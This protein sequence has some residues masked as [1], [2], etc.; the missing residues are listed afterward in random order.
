MK[1]NPERRIANNLWIITA[2][3]VVGIFAPSVFGMDGFSGGFAISF[4][5][6]FIAISGIIA[7]LVYMNRAKALDRLFKDE[8]LLAHWSYTADEWRQYTETDYKADSKGKWSLFYVVAVI[9]LAVGLIFLIFAGEGGVFV[10]FVM[11]GLIALIAF[12]AWFSARHAYNQ[13]RKSVGE[14]FIS[15]E[16]VFLNRQFH[17]WKGLAA[18]LDS[19]A[20]IEEKGQSLVAFT[21]SMPSR[22]GMEERTVRVPVPVGKEEEARKI[23][24]MLKPK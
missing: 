7:A 4:I 11:L 14:A 15:R 16:G 24:E 1:D 12:V 19:V 17:T 10:F 2:A 22:V 6:F 8:N 21:Y 23:A 18:N 3:A 9:S 20:I 13:N 5:A